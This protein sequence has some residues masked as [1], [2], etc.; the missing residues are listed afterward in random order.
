MEP[1]NEEQQ[2]VV[3]EKEQQAIAATQDLVLYQQPDT[4]SINSHPSRCTNMPS[5]TAAA[6]PP[7][8]RPWR[9]AQLVLSVPKR[10]Y[11]ECM[12]KQT[13]NTAVRRTLGIVT[14]RTL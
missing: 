4:V 14:N 6:K 12:L 3:V 10:Q 1:G 7:K 8:A 13:Q 2:E 9:P 5:A 11:L